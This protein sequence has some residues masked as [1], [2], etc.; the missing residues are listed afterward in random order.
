MT[1]GGIKTKSDIDRMLTPVSPIWKG[2]PA[3]YKDAQRSLL[4][5]TSWE[6]LQRCCR[7][8]N[9]NIEGLMDVLGL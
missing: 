8:L 7:V 2:R 6:T 3:L 5:H 1:S 4:K 9:V